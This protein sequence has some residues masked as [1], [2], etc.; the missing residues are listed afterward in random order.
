MRGKGW[1]SERGLAMEVDDEKDKGAA[2]VKGGEYGG[3]DGEEV[4]MAGIEPS[5]D[6]KAE[7]DQE[8]GEDSE[9][10]KDGEESYVGSESREESEDELPGGGYQ[11]RLLCEPFSSARLPLATRTAS[12]SRLM[13][14]SPST[15]RSRPTQVE[16]AAHKAARPHSYKDCHLCNCIVEVRVRRKV[17]RSESIY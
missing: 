10:G 7:G 1:A 17:D 12:C 3:E 8:D 9:R 14:S 11:L 5:G 13:T 4:D 15:G 6:E 16:A 2:A